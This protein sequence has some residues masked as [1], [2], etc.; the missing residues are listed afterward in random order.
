[1]RYVTCE[2]DYEPHE[3]NELCVNPDQVG[4]GHQASR[5]GEREDL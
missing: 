4:N 3:E 5:L 1:M 2:A